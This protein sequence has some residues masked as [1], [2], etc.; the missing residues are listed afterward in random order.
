MDKSVLITGIGCLI[1]MGLVAFRYALFG[2]FLPKKIVK[3][4]AEMS[5]KELSKQKKLTKSKKSPIKCKK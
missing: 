2:D 1:V 3:P 5:A 4:Y